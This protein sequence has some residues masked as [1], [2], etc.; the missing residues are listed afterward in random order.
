MHAKHPKIAARWDRETGGKVA[1]KKVTLPAKKASAVKGSATRA[2]AG[3]AARSAG[4]VKKINKSPVVQKANKY[5]ALK[6]G[7]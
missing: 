4:A 3:P 6:R 5:K 7:K 1:A 2:V